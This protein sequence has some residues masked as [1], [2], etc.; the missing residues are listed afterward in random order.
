MIWDGVQ[1]VALRHEIQDDPAGRGYAAMSPADKLAT[2]RARTIPKRQLVPLWQIKKRAL[3]Q[4][5]WL[6]IKKARTS[7]ASE[8][9]RDAAEAFW[10]YYE[11]PRFE[12]LDM[13]L[14]A[15]EAILS[16]LVAGLVL[17]PDPESAQAEAD[18]LNAMADTFTSPEAE[19]GLADTTLADIV[20]LGV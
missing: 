2:F 17:G 16:A 20:R 6:A 1:D 15:T 14:E 19:C 18:A 9:V 13:D 3:E 7:H 5:Y 8:A 12:N 10:D 4:G 11:D